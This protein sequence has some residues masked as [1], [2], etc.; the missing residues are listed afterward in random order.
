MALRIAQINGSAYTAVHIERLLRVTERGTALLNQMRGDR[1]ADLK[2]PERLALRYAELLTTDIYGVDDDTFRQVRGYYND[3]DVVELTFTTCFFN[4]FT[5]LNEGLG[6][7]LEPW[8]FD[9]AVKPPP[10]KIRKVESPIPRV[11][12]M[13]GTLYQSDN[14]CHADRHEHS[15][16]PLNGLHDSSANE[17]LTILDSYSKCRAL[18]SKYRFTSGAVRSSGKTSTEST[19]A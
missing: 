16:N 6:L 10:T 8:V 5:R 12:L 2:S 11:A 19:R 3:A 18:I 15:G 14:T 1:H 7:P 17:G 9:V 13:A 4:Y